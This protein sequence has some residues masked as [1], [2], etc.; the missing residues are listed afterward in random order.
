MLYLIHDVE[1]ILTVE[2]FL[3]KHSDRIPI[4]VTSMEFTMAFSLLWIVAA[5]GCYQASRNKT[6]L[7][8]TPITFI[9]FL[10][11]GILLANGVGHVFQFIFFRDYVPGILTSI[12]IIFPYSYV[13]LHYLFSK[14][15][16]THKKF[17]LF[18]LLGFVLQAPLAALAIWVSKTVLNL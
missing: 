1:E 13:V 17:I 15:L 4:K 8:M 18:F 7:G 14:N 9:S 16:L 3:M 10:V 12:L 2:K 6:F 11:P 5:I